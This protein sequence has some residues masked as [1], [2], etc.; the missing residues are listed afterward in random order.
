MGNGHTIY[1]PP[2]PRPPR[3]TAH[4]WLALVVG[5]IVGLLI[6][7]LL[8][9]RMPQQRAAQCPPCPRGQTCLRGVCVD[10]AGDQHAC[11]GPRTMI[12]VI[13]GE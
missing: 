2:V 10:V 4:V 5:L 11:T 9:S 6:G 13:V 1:E 8:G 7:L 3:S 12:Q